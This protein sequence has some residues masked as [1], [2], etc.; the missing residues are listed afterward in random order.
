M[1]MPHLPRQ[2]RQ[3]APVDDS[4]LSPRAADRLEKLENISRR[5]ACRWRKAR[6]LHGPRRTRA[7]KHPPRPQAAGAP[8]GAGGRRPAQTRHP[9]M[10]ARP[11][12]VLL[13]R[14]G[15]AL[16]RG[17][18]GR[19]VRH[20]LERRLIRPVARLRGRAGPRERRDFSDGY[21]QRR[22][23]GARARNPGELVQIDRM[24]V[25]RDGQ[26]LEEFRRTSQSA[27]SDPVTRFLVGR[28]Y[29]R[30]TANNARRFL[31]AVGADMPFPL[32][33]IQADGGSEF[34][35]RFEQRCA[36][37]ERPLHVLPPRRPRWNG[38]VERCNDTLRLA[39]RA[40][41]V[42]ELAVASVAA[43]LAEHQRWHNHER[44][45]SALDRSPCEHPALL[46][47]TPSSA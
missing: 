15:T 24:T 8:G 17:A 9:F 33:S 16:S 14:E 3:R 32:R 31:D 44:P 10:G 26:T 20:C 25:H 6:K 42:G 18:V 40:L 12:R 22:K 27:P 45:H 1:Q 46:E 5:T 29:S 36:E 11:L 38:R 28:A 2:V 39:F 34:T 41:H 47:S 21:A 35:A 4:A 13:A 23:Y 30:A 19:I 37:R 43:S 7:A